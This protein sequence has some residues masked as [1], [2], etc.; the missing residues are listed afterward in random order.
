MRRYIGALPLIHY[1]AQARPCRGNVES[2]AVGSSSS[3]STSTQRLQML[4]QSVRERNLQAAQEQAASLLHDHWRD[5][6]VVPLI[7]TA[8]LIVGYYHAESN[9]RQVERRCDAAEKK[10]QEDLTALRND[11][12]NLVQRWESDS[13]QRGRHITDYYRQ[14]RGLTALIDQFTAQLR[15]RC[16]VQSDS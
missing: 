8:V 7:C 3:P 12:Q 6:F 14:N 10:A 2:G 15:N 16:R 4:Q 1:C 13:A 11:V 5:E 9:R